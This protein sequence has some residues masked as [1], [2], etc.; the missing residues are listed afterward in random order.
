MK[1]FLVWICY[2][3]YLLYSSICIFKVFFDYQFVKCYI[4]QIS[5]NSV[6]YWVSMKDLYFTSYNP[7]FKGREIKYWLF[8]NIV[9]LKTCFLY[10]FCLPFSGHCIHL[11]LSCPYFE[12]V[13]V[14]PPGIIFSGSNYFCICLFNLIKNQKN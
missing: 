13:D 10:L 8:R 4:L 11:S 7:Q 12:K 3:T 14:G 5:T 2:P 1:L 9:S 6:I